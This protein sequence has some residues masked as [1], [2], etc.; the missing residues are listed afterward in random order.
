MNKSASREYLASEM[1]EVATFDEPAALSAAQRGC[2]DAFG[3][4]VKFYYKRV[5]GVAYGLVGNREDAMELAQE[6]FARAYRAIARFDTR[7]PFYPWIHRITRNTCLNYL[8]KRRRRGEI[9]LDLLAET[10][11]DPPAEDRG[12]DAN[13]ELSDLSCAIGRAMGRLTPEHREI[14]VLRHFEELS[15]AEIAECLDIPKGTVMSRLHAARRSLRTLI[16]QE[17]QSRPEA[18]T[19]G[20]V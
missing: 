1:I 17:D 10:G 9:S 14:L 19:R 5:Y 15:Y 6:S 4:L 20:D 8:K 7:M 3:S 13:A 11:Y 12:P 16:D 2:R 18:V